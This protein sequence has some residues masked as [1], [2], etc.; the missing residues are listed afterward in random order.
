MKIDSHM[1]PENVGQSRGAKTTQKTTGS[2]PKKTTADVK[3]AAD[4]VAISNKS[5]EIADIMSAVNEL[6]DVR[7]ARVNE[8]KQSV[9]AGTYTVDPRKIAANIIK[10]I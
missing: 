9:D 6:P 5:K 4:T 1:T 7:E 10:E 8:I 2:D 3:N